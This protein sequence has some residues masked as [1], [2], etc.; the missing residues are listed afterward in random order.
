MAA[1]ALNK[2]GW[3]ERET[4]GGER[5]EKERGRK[6]KRG[7]VAPLSPRTGDQV[8]PLAAHGRL[9]RP[10]PGWRR[11]P[12][13]ERENRIGVWVSDGEELCWWWRW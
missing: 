7:A 2:G 13:K 11:P 10:S 1:G 6:R 12:L 8:G 4:Q 5:S 9:R 3:R